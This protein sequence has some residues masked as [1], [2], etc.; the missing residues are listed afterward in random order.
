MGFTDFSL[1]LLPLCLIWSL[2]P[3][4]LLKLLAIASVF[5]AAAALTIGSFGVQPGLL[6]ALA[7]IAFMC[8][9]FLLGARFPAGALV[10]RITRPFVLVTLYALVTSF[11]MPM[12]F[13]GKVF[14]WPQ[15]AE[16]PFILTA[17]APSPANLNQD[18]YLALNCIFLLL[19]ATFLTK[20]RLDL[21]SF[22]RVYLASG[23]VVAAVAAWQ[24]ASRVAGVPFPEDLFYS[25][26]G[27]S[28]LTDQSI[29]GVPRINGPFSEP[30]SLGGYMAS[31]MCASAWLLLQ[32][33]RDK[34]LR[35]LL[36][37]SLGT[38]LMSTSTTG[39]GVLAL[40]CIGVPTVALL[41]GSG[42]LIAS[43]FKIGVPVLLLGGF[44]F[45]S[46]S[47]LLPG[48]GESITEVVTASLDKQQS[49]SYDDRTNADLDSINAMVDTYGL[50]VGWGSNRSSSL[51][52]GLLASVGI[53]GVLGLLWFGASIAREV[54]AAHRQGATPEQKLVLDGCCGALTGFL[55]GAFLSGPTINTI[56]FYFLVALLIA[57]A[58]RVTR[59]ARTA[60]SWMRPP[61]PAR[62]PSGGQ[63]EGSVV[64]RL[65]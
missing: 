33:R 41:R 8:L 28:I 61:R 15:K 5:E 35:W 9:Q 46:A 23:F 12:V 36:A 32:G 64:A 19:T 31:I 18:I 40:V 37:V 7:F 29:G 34:M 45:V 24:F 26:P 60:R 14:V 21:G 58:V 57:C 30:S 44:L 38:M 10:W 6:P 53:P 17:L 16:P 11:V 3:D 43:I 25:N 65:P 20:S 56:T 22:M 47:L 4:K 39:F 13:Q 55:L 62:A 27:W 59:D 48:V 51:I 52:P 1:I 63:K 49:S 2:S 50:G 54:W 42:R